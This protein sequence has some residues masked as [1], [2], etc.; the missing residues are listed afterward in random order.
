M[1]GLLGAGAAPAGVLAGRSS[2]ANAWPPTNP[3]NYAA[4]VA[5]LAQRYGTRLAAIEVW[6]EPDQANQAYF[7]GPE[8]AV[9]AM[10]RSC[11]RP[12]R[13]SSRRTRSVPVLAGSL[14]GSNGI[15]LRALYAAGI[16]GYYDGL[17]VHF[18]TLTLASLRSI[19][20]VQLAN[21]DTTPLW[22]DEFGWSSCWPRLKLQQEQPMRDCSQTQAH[23]ITTP[24]RE[25]ARTPYV[26]AEVL[27]QLAGSTAPETLGF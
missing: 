22:L 12:I 7:A 19:H 15:F 13:R 18:Y 11:G 10:R 14:V 16:K 1:L 20:E 26:A 27:Y 8:K 17:A 24:V 23:N 3:S 9:S 4:F 21:G 6:N 25:L 5:Y 2:E